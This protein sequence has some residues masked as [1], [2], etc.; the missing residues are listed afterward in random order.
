MERE[1]ET[2]IESYFALSPDQRAAYLDNEIREME[3]RRNEFERRR[4][5]DGQGANGNNPGPP[6]G[7]PGGPMGGPGGP[8]GRRGG[9]GGPG[10]PPGPWDMASDAGKLR[11]NDMFDHLSPAKRAK[12]DVF[13][14]DMA[15]R[16]IAQGLPARPSPPGPPPGG[17]PR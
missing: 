6:P 2:R 13:F 11:R 3:K 1:M 16:R 10:G 4:Q 12:L 8:G 5:Q 17:P 14:T 9:P 15:K 7:G